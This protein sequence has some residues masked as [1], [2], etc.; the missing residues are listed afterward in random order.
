MEKDTQQCSL[1]YAQADM[2]M[3]VYT[4]TYTHTHSKVEAKQQRQMG[5]EARM[6]EEIWG[7]FPSESPHIL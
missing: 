6:N 7:L 3:C 1:T 4:H 5:Q 2:I